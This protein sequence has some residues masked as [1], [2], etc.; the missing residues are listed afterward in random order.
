MKIFDGKGFLQT[1]IITDFLPIYPKLKILVINI[2]NI[3]ISEIIL[4]PNPEN[5]LKSRQPVCFIEKL[6][7]GESTTKNFIFEVTQTQQ[8]SINFILLFKDKANMVYLSKTETISFQYSPE[9]QKKPLLWK[10]WANEIQT[11]K[12]YQNTSETGLRPENVYLSLI[13]V[14]KA[15]SFREFE[16][17]KGIDPLR[18]YFFLVFDQNGNEFIVHGLSQQQPRE[19]FLLEIFGEDNDQLKRF[20]NMVFS[21]FAGEVFRVKNDQAKYHK[22]INAAFN[23][24]KNIALLSDYLSI[25][26]KISD[27]VL[28]CKDIMHNL[29]LFLE[30]HE[31]QNSLK[32]WF[33]IFNHMLKPSDL[34]PHQYNQLLADIKEWEHIINTIYPIG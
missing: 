26:W 5:T 33:E 14:L 28:V 2:S 10:N 27:I 16:Y 18:E 23:L 30:F 17:R 22:K 12:F 15:F 32:K 29:E 7:P 24:G 25:D 21:D 11:L 1:K 34:P 8:Y 19:L 4:L 3:P 6:L 31:I 9:I 13:N 20:A